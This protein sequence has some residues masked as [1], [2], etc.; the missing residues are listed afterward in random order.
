MYVRIGKAATL[1]EVAKSTLR[2]WKKE[3]KFTADYRTQGGHR[4]YS[5]IRLLQ[6]IR[7]LPAIEK[8]IKTTADTRPQVVT[9]A[10]MSGSKQREDLKRQQEYLKGYVK[11]Q[12]WHLV[13]QYQDIGSGLNDNRQG[14]IWDK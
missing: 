13:K 8:S 10:R 12:G 7:Q 1:L 3:K 9:Y 4:R 11:T 14:L 2:R 6:I 5:M